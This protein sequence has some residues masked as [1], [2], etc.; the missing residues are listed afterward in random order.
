MF[1]GEARTKFNAPLKSEVKLPNFV[2]TTPLPSVSEVA[3]A[4]GTAVAPNSTPLQAAV[5]PFLHWFATCPAPAAKTA[6]LM[7]MEYQSIDMVRPSIQ[8]GVRMMPPEIVVAFSG[9]KALFPDWWT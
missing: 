4:P 2:V 1:T 8:C 5:E 7:L 6:F 9:C 3:M